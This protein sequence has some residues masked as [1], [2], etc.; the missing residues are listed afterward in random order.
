MASEVGSS[1]PYAA[2]SGSVGAPGAD[3]GEAPQRMRGTVIA[4]GVIFVIDAFLMC[5]GVWSLLGAVVL[6]IVTLAT[7]RKTSNVR[8]VVARLAI[9]ILLAP[10]VWASLYAQNELARA[11]AATVIA[12]VDRYHA[13]RGS[14]PKALADLVPTYLPSIPRAKYQTFGEFTY[15]DGRTGDP[16]AEQRPILLYVALPPFGRPT[17]DFRS[18]S[19]GYID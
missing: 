13:E 15:I 12:A 11:R 7:I 6:L 14:Y 2:P 17:Y 18:H 10:S 5:Q 4:A 16:G 8:V 19:W 1:N 3:A 9:A